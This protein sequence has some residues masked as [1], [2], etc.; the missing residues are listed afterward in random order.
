MYWAQLL[1]QLDVGCVLLH[2]AKDEE[3]QQMFI[4]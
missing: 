4:D 1:M 3:K 2:E